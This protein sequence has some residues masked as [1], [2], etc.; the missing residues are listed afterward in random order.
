MSAKGSKDLRFSIDI[1]SM[2]WFF[3]DFE[4]DKDSNGDS[5]YCKKIFLVGDLL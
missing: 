2:N 1:Y 3:G 5:F 4:E